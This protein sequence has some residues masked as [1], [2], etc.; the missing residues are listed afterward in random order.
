MA[1]RS[2][3]SNKGFYGIKKRNAL[4]SKATELSGN[5]PDLEVVMKLREGISHA[6][7]MVSLICRYLASSKPHR[8]LARHLLDKLTRLPVPFTAGGRAAPGISVD[9]YTAFK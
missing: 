8:R 9:T 5:K 7:R 6:W 4:R 1:G 2:T 3:A